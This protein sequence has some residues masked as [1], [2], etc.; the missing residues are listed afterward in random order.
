MI[1]G[2]N[3]RV[4][5]NKIYI[6]QSWCA[7]MCVFRVDQLLLDGREVSDI[8]FSPRGPG[9]LF[10]NGAMGYYIP[11]AGSGFVR[12]GLDKGVRFRRCFVRC[13]WLGGL[14][15]LKSYLPVEV[16]NCYFLSL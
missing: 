1:L 8:D 14:L 16:W 9:R 5:Q 11:G 7:F 13:G 3:C 4:E 12:S 15:L 10:A 6:M 2:A